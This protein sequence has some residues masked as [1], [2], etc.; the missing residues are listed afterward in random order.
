MALS[1]ENKVKKDIE[2][3][4][5]WAETRKMGRTKFILIYGVLFW[6]L[7]MAL[8]FFFLGLKDS[9]QPWYSQLLI[10]IIVFCPGGF[11]FGHFTWKSAEK[12]YHSGSDK[13]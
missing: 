3:K 5:N 2:N 13:N 9:S 10:S 7:L 12:K 11:L 6:G 4:K 1:N 8:V